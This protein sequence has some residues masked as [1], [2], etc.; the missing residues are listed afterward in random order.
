MLRIHEI[1]D[2]IHTFIRLDSQERKVLDSRPLQRLR[3]V[4][5][6]AL[7]YL[8]YPGASHRRFEHSLGVME[9]ATRVFDVV[10]SSHS[11]KHDAVRS[12]VPDGDELAYWKRV[13]RMAALCHDVGHLPFSHAAESELLPNGWDHER[14]TADIIRSN[15]M[16][17]LWKN[18]TPPLRSDDIVKLAVGPK[19]LDHLDFTD[20]EALLAEI[21][22]GDAFGSDR[23]DYLLR[24][25][26]HAGVAYG[27][28]DHYRLIDTL[29]ILP[30][31]QQGS[32]EPAMGV[33]EGGLQSAEALLMARYFM[34]TQ[35]YLHPVRRIYDIHLKDFLKSWLPGGRFSTSIEDHLRLTDNEVG[36]ALLE[37]ARTPGSGA[38]VHAGRIVDRDH[39]RLCYK[40]NPIDISSNPE[41]PQAVY[42]A[43]CK[44]FGQGSVRCDSWKDKNSYVDFP[45]L[46]KDGRIVSSLSTSETLAHLPPIAVDLVFVEPSKLVEAKSWL[47]TEREEIIKPGPSEDDNE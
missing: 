21:I 40:R 12:I 20:W 7:S 18:L 33:D 27:R 38:H 14:L 11:I 31:E 4:H 30:S 22:V 41:A 46:S 3:H 28:F 37:A 32:Q 2:P 5:Q 29:R 10:T 9:L 15:E 42:Q 23:M 25:S 16:E 44:R 6:L 43:A 34:Y 47:E 1:R 19:K 35:V 17:D 36:A 13:L 45:I 26:H 8:V 24:D 39:Y